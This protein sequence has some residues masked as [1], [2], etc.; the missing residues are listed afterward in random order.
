VNQFRVFETVLE[1]HQFL[2]ELGASPQLIVHVKLVCEAAELL[3]AQLDRVAIFVD[4]YFLGT[5]VLGTS[6]GDDRV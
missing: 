3:I 1:A 6:Q 4:K 5:V 2:E